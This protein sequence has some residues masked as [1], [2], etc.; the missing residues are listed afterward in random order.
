MTPIP[1]LLFAINP[2]PFGANEMRCLYRKAHRRAIGAQA[3]A[4]GKL[5][6]A[7]SISVPAPTAVPTAAAQQNKKKHYD[8]NRGGA[9]ACLL[10]RYV[11]R[12]LRDALQLQATFGIAI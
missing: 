5:R 9:H 1:P 10:K 2:C 12:A 4:E 7:S 3:R 6:S 8:E 11:S